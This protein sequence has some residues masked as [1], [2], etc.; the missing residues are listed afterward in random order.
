MP[1]YIGEIRIFAGGFAPLGWLLCQGQSLA[2]ADYQSL[3][4]RIHN[5]YGGDGESTFNLPDFRGRVPVHANSPQYNLG[6]QLGT[7]TVTLAT[8]QIP[9][10]N[11][12]MLASTA[13]ATTGNP[14]GAFVAQSSSAAFYSNKAPDGELSEL[15]IGNTGGGQAHENMMPFVALNF[16]IATEGV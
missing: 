15:G 7:E 2:I 12:P 8:S 4:E 13:A 14:Q 1:P 6:N 5:D 16:I 3:F 9:L 11:H 10:H